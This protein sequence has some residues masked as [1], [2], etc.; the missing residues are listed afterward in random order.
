M[1]DVSDDKNKGKWPVSG[2]KPTFMHLSVAIIYIKY[3]G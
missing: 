1:R 3:R 2:L